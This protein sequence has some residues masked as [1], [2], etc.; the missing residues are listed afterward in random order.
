MP[1]HGHS[2]RE[3]YWLYNTR[4]SKGSENE[5][6]EKIFKYNSLI[7]WFEG[8]GSRSTEKLNLYVEITLDNI[9]IDQRY[10]T[11][12]EYILLDKLSRVINE[13]SRDYV[14]QDKSIREK[15]Q[16]SAQST[17]ERVIK[18]SGMFYNIKTDKFIFK[19]NFNVPLL[20]AISVNAKSTVQALKDIFKHIED[21]IKNIN[22]DE[23]KPLIDVYVKQ[24][25]I[26]Q[27]LK[28]N[29]L[30]VFIADGSILPRESGTNLPLKDAAP[31]SHLQ[32]CV[33]RYRL[34]MVQRFPEWQLS[35]E[36][37]LLQA[38]HIPGNPLY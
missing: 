30:C 14:N 2:K 20:N 26:R 9:Y 31:F 11:I 33:Y 5:E 29:N 38:V 3:L 27:Y 17:D 6:S 35:K 36:L 23:I 7:F 24:L 15:A 28:E 18:R 22:E 4:F 34:K 8:M 13:L 25:E 16:F 12:Y 21:I 32:I 1:M 10:V 19:I 37:Q